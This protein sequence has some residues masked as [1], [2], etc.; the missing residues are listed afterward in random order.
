MKGQLDIIDKFFM[1][2]N[3]AYEET[4]ESIYEELHVSKEDYLND[5]LKMIKRFKLKSKVIANKAKNEKLFNLAI[6]RIQDV[7][8]SSDEKLKE[9]IE[10]LIFQRSPLFQFRNIEKLDKEDLIELLGDL[11]IIE[12]IEE[13]EKSNN[14]K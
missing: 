7:I 11:N 13:L 12:I 6:Q 4:N 10:Q 3:D 2:S 1:L 5:K 9:K 8:K 14:D